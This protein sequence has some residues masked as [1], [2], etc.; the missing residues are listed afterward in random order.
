MLYNWMV[1]KY[2]AA[3][4][5]RIFVLGQLPTEPERLQIVPGHSATD[6]RQLCTADTAAQLL[7]TGSHGN[8]VLGVI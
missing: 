1:Y 6:A 3:L 4:S 8:T 7:Q 5:E 2:I